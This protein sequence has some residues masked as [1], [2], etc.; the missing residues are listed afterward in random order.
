VEIP[1]DSRGSQRAV[2]KSKGCVLGQVSLVRSDDRQNVNITITSK[3]AA[4]YLG[5][6]E[7]E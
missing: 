5:D 1:D 7:I 3:N 4:W 2:I 6:D